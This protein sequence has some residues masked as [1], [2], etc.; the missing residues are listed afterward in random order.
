MMKRLPLYALSALAL[1]CTESLSLDPMVSQRRY[2]PYQ[3]SFFFTDGRAM[4]APPDGTVAFGADDASP[5]PPQV[6]RALLERGRNRFDVFCATCH[7]LTGDGRSLVAQNMALRPPPSLHAHRHHADASS[8]YTIATEGFG[9]MPGYSS[10][11]TDDERWA[12]AFY[13]LALQ[14]SQWAPLEDA[15]PEVRRRLEQEA[16]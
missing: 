1:G 10:Q 2:G 15:P 4:Q 11:M 3:E 5:V 12:V 14:R 8:F 6:T 16:P 7:G 9:L 13:V